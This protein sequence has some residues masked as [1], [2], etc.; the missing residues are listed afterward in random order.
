MSSSQPET[1]LRITPGF[2]WRWEGKLFW[3]V[4]NTPVPP[5]GR[6]VCKRQRG[7]ELQRNASGAHLS[8]Q[9]SHVAQQVTKYQGCKGRNGPLSL[10]G[11]QHPHRALPG[12]FRAQRDAGCSGSSGQ[13]DTEKSGE[14][15]RARS[16]AGSLPLVQSRMHSL[17]RDGAILMSPKG[18]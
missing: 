14:N 12:G 18:D 13:Q 6:V 11:Q 15:S 10:P 16:T 17:E 4:G 3:W 9:V 8:L 5:A 1:S 7:K 2:G